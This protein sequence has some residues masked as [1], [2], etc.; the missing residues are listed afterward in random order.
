M[1]DPEQV[2]SFTTEPRPVAQY[3][4]AYDSIISGGLPYLVAVEDES[5]PSSTVIGYANAHDFRGGV[6]SAYRH[7]VEISLFCHP[8]HRGNGAGSLL[9]ESLISALK[10]PAGHPELYLLDVR[11]KEREVKEVVAVMAVD[12]LAEGGGLRLKAFYERFGFVLV[13]LSSTVAE[14]RE[15]WFEELT[16][17]CREDISRGLGISLAGG[18]LPRWFEYSLPLCRS[19]R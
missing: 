16:R 19:A 10:D 11:G 14:V 8:D 3:Q 5:Q 2:N 12:D 4:S 7:T 13:S 6:N 17:G 15:Q 9:L 18:T 1:T